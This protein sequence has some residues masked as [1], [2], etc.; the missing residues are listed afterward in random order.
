MNTFGQ[1]SVECSRHAEGL[2]ELD[3]SWRISSPDTDAHAV[4]S[5][6]ADRIDL[7]DNSSQPRSDRPL[8]IS[9]PIVASGER[10]PGKARMSFSATATPVCAVILAGSVTLPVN[11]RGAR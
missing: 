4:R 11:L 8:T 1:C 7:R 6:C 3:T 2:T 5:K 9:I 10:K